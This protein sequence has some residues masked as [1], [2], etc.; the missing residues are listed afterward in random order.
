MANR[1]SSALNYGWSSHLGTLLASEQNRE[2]V[3]PS[4]RS[5]GPLRLWRVSLN[6]GTPEPITSGG[7]DVYRPSIAKHGDRLTYV[8]DAGNNN[9]WRIPL[10]ASG[11]LAG[12]PSR[13]IYSTRYQQDPQY[14]A[15]GTRIAYSSDRSGSNEVWVSDAE[16]RTSTQLT[17]F[18]G[19]ATGTARWSPD[20]NW[21][22]FDTRASGNP[23]VFIMKSDGG[24]LKRLTTSDA[25]D[26]VPSW[27]HDGKWVYFASNRTGDLQIWKVLANIGETLVNPPV[28][29]T[30]RGGF[31]AWESSDAKYLYF[32]RSRGQP[33]LWR[34]SLITGGEEPVL[35]SLQDWGWWTLAPQGLFFFHPAETGNKRQARLMLSDLTGQNIRELLEIPKPV[36]YENA[37]LAASPDGRYLAYTQMDQDGSDIMLIENFR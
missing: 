32:N 1:R 30:H 21:L 16:G 10:D 23:D 3:F 29:V 27:S 7:Q 34:M 36:T 8:A 25:E 18:R 26:V 15:D 4:P 13:L 9:L 37:A 5:G 2:I 14:S 24:A 20:S 33:A 19:P 17:H 6:G 12:G 35:D 31:N 28:Q 22:A 11:S